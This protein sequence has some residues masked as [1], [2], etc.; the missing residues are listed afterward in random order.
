MAIWGAP[1]PLEDTQM[2]ACKSA[3]E[4]TKALVH[5]NECLPKGMPKVNSIT[6]TTNLC[7]LHAEWEFTL[8]RYW[9]EILDMNKE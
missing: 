9:W 6:T 7:R 1:E 3:M 5:L 2:L 8:G 4:F